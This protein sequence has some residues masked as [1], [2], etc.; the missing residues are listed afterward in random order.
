MPQYKG[1]K[2]QQIIEW[3]DGPVAALEA[4][5]NSSEWLFLYQR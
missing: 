4:A 2:T 1:V 5:Q 3:Y